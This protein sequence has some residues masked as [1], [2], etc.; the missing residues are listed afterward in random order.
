MQFLADFIIFKCDFYLK[1]QKPNTATF[2]CWLGF[3]LLG[4]ANLFNIELK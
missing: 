1:S 4:V 3:V 2:Y